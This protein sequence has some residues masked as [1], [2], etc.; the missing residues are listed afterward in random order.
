MRSFTLQEE[1]NLK[2]VDY[3]IIQRGLNARQRGL[4]RGLDRHIGQKHL[5][6][7]SIWQQ[8]K[9]ELHITYVDGESVLKQRK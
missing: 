8:G 7:S 4:V 3:T 6:C 2:N 5:A 1:G 9:R